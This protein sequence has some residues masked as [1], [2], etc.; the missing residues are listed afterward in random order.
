MKSNNTISVEDKIKKLSE[1]SNSDRELLEMVWGKHIDWYA[2]DDQGACV[3]IK[4]LPSLTE[5][6][7]EWKNQALHQNNSDL[8]EKIELMRIS[9]KTMQSW[10]Q[11]K[12]DP[13]YDINMA[14][15]KNETLDSVLELLG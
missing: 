9:E 1:I 13:S 6:L 8:K 11:S 5:H 7:I 2:G 4:N 14:N 12:Y 15:E 3:S 10:K